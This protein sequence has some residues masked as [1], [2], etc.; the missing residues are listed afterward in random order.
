MRI[1]R[2]RTQ[3]RSFRKGS[4]VNRSFSS[5]RTCA[6]KGSFF[7]A[8][9]LSGALLGACS[10]GSGASRLAGMPQTAENTIHPQGLRSIGAVLP[11]ATLKGASADYIVYIVNAGNNTVTTYTSK[12]KQTSPTITAGLSVPCGPRSTRTAK[13]TLRI[14]R[15]TTFHMCRLTCLTERERPPR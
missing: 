6:A 5:G 3:S 4:I 2:R 15:I 1:T 8:V 7:L 12:G 13:S 9:L 10:G 11:T 14:G